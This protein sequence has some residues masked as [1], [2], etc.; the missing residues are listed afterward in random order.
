MVSDYGNMEFGNQKGREQITP[1][2]ARRERQK[3]VVRM[4]KGEVHCGMSFDLN[5]K[6]PEFHLD[7]QN[8]KGESLN[9][10]VRIAFEEVK[11]VF[12]VKSFDGHFIADDFQ[13]WHLPDI[14]PIAIKFFDGEALMGRP[15][16]ASWKEEDRFYLL[17][18]KQDGNNMM[19]LVERSAVESIHDAKSYMQQQQRAYE[20]FKQEHMKPGMPEEECRGDFHFSRQEYNDAMR[21]YR[22]VRDKEPVNERIVRKICAARYNL[23]VRHIRNRDYEQALHDMYLVLK[24]DPHHTHA[25]EKVVQLEAHIAKHR[26]GD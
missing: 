6:M 25:R 5:R 18:E 15:A 23:G 11:A 2:Q 20:T 8:L 24:L 12:Y 7:L 9:R 10:T 14:R 4:K 16:H 1:F 26:H 21:C 17:P 13:A 22:I 3:L 19:I